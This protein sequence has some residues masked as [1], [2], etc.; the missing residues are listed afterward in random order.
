MPLPS[1]LVDLQPGTVIASAVLDAEFLNLYG[2]IN[3]TLQDKGIKVRCNDA[4]IPVSEFDSLTA[5]MIA[6]FSNNGTPVSRINNNGQFE[7]LIATGTAP[8]VVAS[9]TVVANLNVDK[10][11]GFDFTGSR[12][13][14]QSGWFYATAPGA[15]ETNP[16][17]HSFFV[18]FGGTVVIEKLAIVRNGGSHTGGTALTFTLK[19]FN[20]AG[21]AQA[22]IG[23]IGLSDTNSGANIAYLNDIADLGSLAEGDTIFPL[24][25]TRTGAPTESN[26]TVVMYGYQNLRS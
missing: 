2:V 13:A 12:G 4:S 8:F 16:S 1:K 21:A 24:L 18:P 19:R 23:T 20:A 25:T 26:I 7:S 3:G 11:D 22:D 6:R 5:L 17:V 9:T 14:W 10:V 15:V